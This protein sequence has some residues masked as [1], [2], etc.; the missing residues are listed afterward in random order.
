MGPLHRSVLNIGS[1]RR[2][3]GLTDH[4][5]RTGGALHKSTKTASKWPFCVCSTGMEKYDEKCSP[6]YHTLSPCQ[7]KR[8]AR[9]N[10]SVL[11]DGLSL[12]SAGAENGHRRVPLLDK[13]AVAPEYEP[14]L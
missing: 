7:R 5:P 2:L 14:Y 13:P 3:P 8:C 12:N 1:A 6:S 9:R 10:D 4:L 11:W